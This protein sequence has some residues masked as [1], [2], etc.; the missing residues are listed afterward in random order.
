[1]ATYERT[2]TVTIDE[3]D[4][5]LTFRRVSGKVMATVFDGTESETFEVA[6]Y[7]PMNALNVKQI[8][9]DGLTALGHTIKP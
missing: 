9:T 4:A 7:G 1:M 2:L 5:Q 8:V 3:L 6:G